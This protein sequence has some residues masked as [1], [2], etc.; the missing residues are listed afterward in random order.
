MSEVSGRSSHDTRQWFARETI[1][2]TRE[3]AQRWAKTWADAWP[4]KDVDAIVALQTEDG[5]HWASMF[6]PFRGRAGLRS[7]VA[8]SFAEESRPAEVWF[9]EPQ[10]DGDMAAVEY[11]AVIYIKDQPM[12]ISGCTLLRFN[13]AG[14]VAGARDYSHVKEGSHSLPAGVFE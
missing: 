14:L 9:A 5:D 8:E 6:R 3:A 10:V 7:Y 1:V 4:I 11:W 13:E 12:T 2:E